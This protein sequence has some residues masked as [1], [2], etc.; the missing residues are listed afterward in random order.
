MN[1]ASEGTILPGVEEE[2][3]ELGGIDRRVAKP[4]TEEE[5]RALLNH[6][7]ERM[8]RGDHQP[9]AFLGRGTSME[10]C[11]PSLWNNAASQNALWISMESLVATGGTGIVEYVPGDGTLTAQA[12]ASMETLRA[13]VNEGGHRI[14]PAGPAPG[15]TLGGLLASG[16]S[17]IDRCGFG[18]AR[19]HVLGMRI[20]DA[21]G[22]GPIKSG[23]RLVKNVTGFDLHRL[24]VGGRGTLGAILEASLRLVPVPE[25]EAFVAST[26]FATAAEATAAGLEVRAQRGIQPRALFVASQQVHV[27]VA[28]RERQ[29]EEEL[30]RI[31]KI[32]TL[33]SVER[34]PHAE[35]QALKAA[36]RRSI[37][38]IATAPS[39]I[40]DIVEGLEAAGLRS[41]YVEPD[42][43]ALEFDED[44]LAEVADSASL[45]GLFDPRHHFVNML[46]ATPQLEGLQRALADRQSPPPAVRVWIERLQS[47]Y[48]PAGILGSADFPLRGSSRP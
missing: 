1:A 6:L 2:L 13:A 39:K 18:P 12:G 23:G 25:A 47:S 24:H 43:A 10:W 44:S 14:T 40:R 30:T 32:L 38:T 19:H 28:G 29:V 21:S 35:S 3:V 11:C 31:E 4:R 45:Q 36:R 15:G 8:A 34:G 5:L 17:C 20:Q 42:A 33:E 41:V 37:V 48:D 9:V 7:K 22:R 26:P 16:R 27:L 46:R